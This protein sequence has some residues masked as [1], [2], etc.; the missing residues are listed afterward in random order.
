MGAYRSQHFVPRSYL[1][2]FSVSENPKSVGL[3]NIDR[4]IYVDQA[5]IKSQCAKP[6][7]YGKDKLEKILAEVEGKYDQWIGRGVLA[8]PAMLI[9]DLDQ[10]V[11][12]F[13]LLQYLRT[14]YALMRIRAQINLLDQLAKIPTDSEFSL[15]R[16]D[17]SDTALARDGVQMA[18]SVQD[19][20]SDLAMVFVRNIS[21]RPFVTCDDPVVFSNRVY[22][23]RLRATNFG[24]GSSGVLFYLPLSPSVAAM[25]YDRDAYAVP[26]DSRLWVTLD[27]NNDAAAFND[28]VFLKARE[29][30]YFR[31]RS[32]FDEQRFHH[33]KDRRLEEWQAG[34]VLVPVE[35]TS[36]GT[37]YKEVDEV[38]ESGNYIIATSSRFPTPERWPSIVRMKGPVIAYTNGSAAGHVRRHTAELDRMRVAKV[39]L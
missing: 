8:A 18:L 22:I 27:R 35:E 23:Q 6:F 9:D 7:L 11:R 17:T 25:L 4:D 3:Y 12:F 15:E 28:L 29:N 24:F 37:T 21:S 1:K 34:S 39:R 13:T 38:P 14:E 19:V 2:H 26:K 10:F 31:D 30:I 36:T 20:V 33:L 5:P 32:H 16:I